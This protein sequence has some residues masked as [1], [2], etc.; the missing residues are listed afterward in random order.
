[1]A[2]LFLHQLSDA[3]ELFEKNTPGIAIFQFNIAIL[4]LCYSRSVK[5]ILLRP[6]GLFVFALKIMGLSQVL[7]PLILNI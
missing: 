5:F 3:K 6:A 4:P 7:P 1:M 2:N